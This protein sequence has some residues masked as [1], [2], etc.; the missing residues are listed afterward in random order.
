M[1]NTTPT[2]PAVP[3]E[4]REQLLAIS[5][6][7]EIPPATVANE[8]VTLYIK[9]EPLLALF[10]QY[11]RQ[12]RAAAIESYKKI[13]AMEAQLTATPHEGEVEDE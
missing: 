7:V 13:L 8:N 2:D 11:A 9:L 4:L 6:G 3:D 5:H 10:T 1:T 12:E